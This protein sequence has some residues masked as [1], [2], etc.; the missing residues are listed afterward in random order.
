M[1]PNP[2]SSENHLTVPVPTD[3]TPLAAVV[4]QVRSVPCAPYYFGRLLVP[5]LTCRR[6]PEAVSRRKRKSRASGASGAR[7]RQPPASGQRGPRQMLSPE[8]RSLGGER[9]RSGSKPNR[10]VRAVGRVTNAP[11][12]VVGSPLAL[13]RRTR[14]ASEPPSAGLV[15]HGRYSG[16]WASARVFT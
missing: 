4:A 1:N 7:S 11:P 15:A 14:P 3:L 10:I 16:A 8:K 13:L 5:A 2:L 6:Y 9:S 12:T